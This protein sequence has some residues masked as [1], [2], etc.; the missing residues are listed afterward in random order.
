MPVMRKKKRIDYV[1][2]FLFCS[3]FYL[4][5]IMCLR[6]TSVVK[7]IPKLATPTVSFK[8]FNF[9]F[10]FRNVTFCFENGHSKHN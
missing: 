8:F 7:C 4:Q 6:K 2:D 9:N 5:K 3:V 1:G 10:K